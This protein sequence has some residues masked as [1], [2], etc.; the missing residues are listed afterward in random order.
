MTI[1]E[2]LEAL[3]SKIKVIGINALLEI[4]KTENQEWG[5]EY[6]ANDRLSYYFRHQGTLRDSLEAVYQDLKDNNLL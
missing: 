6:I 4:Y 2:L 1:E 5:V 3:P